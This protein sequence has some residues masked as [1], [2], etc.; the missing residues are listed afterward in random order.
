MITAQNVTIDVP[1]VEGLKFELLCE[2]PIA[3]LWAQESI[4]VPVRVTAEVEYD[5]VV[6]T[7]SRITNTSSGAGVDDPSRIVSY[8]T[9]FKSAEARAGWGTKCLTSDGKSIGILLFRKV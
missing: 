7:H 8:R 1:E 3:Q 2:N 6:F 9:K 5:D 4:I